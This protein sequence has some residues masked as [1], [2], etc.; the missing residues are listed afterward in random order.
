MLFPNVPVIECCVRDGT[1]FNRVETSNPGESRLIPALE[2]GTG[3]DCTEL[4]KSF[5]EVAFKVLS[6]M[7]A[8]PLLDG[9]SAEFK[10]LKLAQVPVVF[11]ECFPSRLIGLS[12]YEIANCNHR[13]KFG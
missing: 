8:L 13:P 6:E 9:V 4:L 5:G 1:I 2:E 11:Y 10:N 3:C 7:F 12:E